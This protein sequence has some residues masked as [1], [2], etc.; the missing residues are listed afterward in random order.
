[1]ETLLLHTSL[2]YWS[3]WRVSIG[4][5][6]AATCREMVQDTFSYFPR[7]M[8]DAD[9]RALTQCLVHHTVTLS[10]ADKSGNLV[11]GRVCRKIKVQPDALKPHRCVFGYPEG[12]ANI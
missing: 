9:V 7:A 2:V 10:E 4:G 1:M 3:G 8:R 5:K 12:A 11:F 6:P